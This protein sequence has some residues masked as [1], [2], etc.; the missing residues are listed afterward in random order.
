MSKRYK[1]FEELSARQK[2]RCLNIIHQN[3]QNAEENSDSSEFDQEDVRGVNNDFY[4]GVD[5][6]SDGHIYGDNRNNDVEQNITD[7]DAESESFHGDDIGEDLD[8]LEV[9]V[10]IDNESASNESSGSEE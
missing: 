7:D 9:L 8:D 3:R 2:R 1:T 10:G 4:D 5:S 6:D